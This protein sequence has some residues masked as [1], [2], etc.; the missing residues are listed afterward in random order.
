[1]GWTTGVLGFNYRRWLGIFLFNI[2]SRTALGP[3]QPPIQW[4]RGALPLGVNWT[5]R[6]ADHSSPSSAEV[7]ECVELYINSTH[8]PSLRGAQLK[9]K[10]KAQGKFYFHLYLKK[11]EIR[12]TEFQYSDQLT[13]HFLIL[14]HN[15]HVT[16][17][18]Q[19]AE[20]L[21]SQTELSNR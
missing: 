19:R 11:Y 8:T 7:K 9:T 5:W 21:S 1:M 17:S 2:A 3:T 14:S 18:Q 16:F 6:E 20:Q 4:V 13:S 12:I 15:F 10:K